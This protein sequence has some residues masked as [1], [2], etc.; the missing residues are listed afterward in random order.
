VGLPALS[1]PTGQNVKRAS[2][3][4]EG[5]VLDHCSRV[6]TEAHLKAVAD[7]ILAAIP[8]GLVSAVF[9][10]SLGGHEADWTPALPQEFHRRRG[11]D[12][13]PELPLLYARGGGCE[14]VRADIAA[15]L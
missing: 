11:Y 12:L 7:P 2:V 4:A 5:P 1:S 14:Q 10:D 15:T 3:G 13:L 9:C 8:S 6:A